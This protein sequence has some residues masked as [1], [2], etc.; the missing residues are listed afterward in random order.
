MSRAV[1]LKDQRG[2]T[3]VELM[4]AMAAGSVVLFALTMMIVVT[5]HTGTRV[6]A[7]VDATQ[8][9]RLV[10]GGIMD[11]LHSAC[12]A[13]GIAPVQT[14]STGTSLEFIHS[15]PATG[16]EVSPKPTLSKISLADGT[17]SQV[18]YE[19]AVEAPPWSFEK[20]TP[21]SERQLM[22]G[23]SPIP[24]SEWIFTYHAYANAAVSA[25]RLPTPLNAVDAERT[26]EVSVALS[27]APGPT[28]VAAGS[29]PTQIQESALLRLTT[30]AFSKET[31]GP[32][33]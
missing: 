14:G 22:T 33:L 9:A 31:D 32:C 2:T 25:T 10:L 26:V 29:A 6:S 8:R 23:I 27:A 28:S 18:D 7:R 16:S 24:P 13:P 20:E 5:L 4:V 30:L 11:Q 12:V 21:S 15:T 3:L 1:A 19:A 17:L